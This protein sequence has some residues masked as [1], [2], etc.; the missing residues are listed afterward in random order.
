[1]SFV[2]PIFELVFFLCLTWLCNATCMNYVKLHCVV[3]LVLH[4]LQRVFFF[5][6]YIVPHIFQTQHLAHTNQ[7]HRL[8]L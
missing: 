2:K 1:M 5:L 6:G 3:L 7:Q 8:Q 4:V